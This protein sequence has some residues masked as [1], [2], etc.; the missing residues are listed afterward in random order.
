MCLC[1][2]V[3]TF[4]GFGQVVFYG[5]KLGPTRFSCVL[6]VVL[7]AVVVFCLC[8][9]VDHPP[10]T[11]TIWITSNRAAEAKERSPYQFVGLGDTSQVKF[12]VHPTKGICFFV[13]NFNNKWR[14]YDVSDVI[15]L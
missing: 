15:V 5:P 9:S 13:V 12:Q 7:L 11:K 14:T 3:Y 6:P 10:P 1:V 8:T 2:R 4:Y